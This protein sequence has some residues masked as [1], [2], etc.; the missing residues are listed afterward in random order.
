MIRQL[1]TALVRAWNPVI[2]QHKNAAVV[3]NIT[4]L[5]PMKIQLLLLEFFSEGMH[6]AT[7]FCFLK[8]VVLAHVSTY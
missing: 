4:S 6:D 5:L 1:D 7:T 3:A 2:L 8:S